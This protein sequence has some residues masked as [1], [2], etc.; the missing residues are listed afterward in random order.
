MNTRTA[1][2]KNTKKRYLINFAMFFLF[3]AVT[4]SSLYFLYVPAGYQGGRNPRYNMQ[5]IF[6]RDTWG[7]IHTWTSFVLS[8]ILL[9]HIILHWSWVQNVFVKY[10]Q[11]WKKGVR[12]RN[13][14]ALLNTIDDGLIAIFFL[15][16]LISGVVLFVVPGG[17]GT[18]N[19]L[20]LAVTRDTWKDIHVWTG[21]G[22]LVGVVL[23]LVIHWGWI[24][25]VSAKIFKRSQ[26]V[27][28]LENGMG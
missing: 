1:L 20:I 8:A 21:I 19:T 13:N 12:S 26:A 15:A 23:H 6:D 9:I 4:L 28:E 17:P 25:K 24:K 18:A 16:C 3:L 11:I 2:S 14:L 27:T 22:M 5:I 7:Q 10:I